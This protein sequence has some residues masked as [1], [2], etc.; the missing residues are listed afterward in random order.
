MNR[1]R[2]QA[3]LAVQRLGI[4]CITPCAAKASVASLATSEG[5]VQRDGHEQHPRQPFQ[6]VH[7][8]PIGIPCFHRRFR[9]PVRPFHHPL[10]HLKFPRPRTLDPPCPLL[11]LFPQASCAYRLQR[12]SLMALYTELTSC[13]NQFTVPSFLECQN[14]RRPRKGPR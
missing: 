4:K 8:S 6:R 10:L 12:L 14:K 13:H 11:L 2:A 7:L 5:A 3:R 1:R 9:I